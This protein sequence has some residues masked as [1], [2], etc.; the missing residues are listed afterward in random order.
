MNA[1]D[2]IWPMPLPTGIRADAPV[3]T[4]AQIIAPRPWPQRPETGRESER[5][6]ARKPT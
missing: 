5:H 4:R 3:R 6:C 2:C 1:Q